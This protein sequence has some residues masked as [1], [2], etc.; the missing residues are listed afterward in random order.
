MEQAL[1]NN[2]TNNKKHPVRRWVF[3]SLAVI[4]NAFII[5]QAS[6]PGEA[7]AL[8]SNFFYNIIRNI[9]NGINGNIAKTIPVDNVLLSYNDSYKY[10]SIEGY[11]NNE[12]PIGVSKSLTASVLP[13]N[14][15]DKMVSFTISD[16][17]KASITSSG[18]NVYVTGLS[19][20]LVTITATSK[21]DINK[22]QT[23]TFNIVEPRVPTSFDYS[24]S[25]LDIY[26]GGQDYLPLVVPNKECYDLTKLTITSLDDSVVSYDDGLLVTHNIG[27]TSI[28]VSNGSVNKSLTVN[29]ID[30]TGATYPI[31]G[32]TVN[33]FD[34]IYVNESKPLSISFIDG[35]FPSETGMIWTSSNPTLASVDSNGVVTAHNKLTSGE[36]IVTITATSK[37]DPTQSVSHNISIINSPVKEFDLVVPVYGTHINDS[38]IDIE[39]TDTYKLFIFFAGYTTDHR[40][41]VTSS[42][43]SVATAELGDGELYITCLKEGQTRISVNN[44][45]YPDVSHYLDV[46]VVPKGAINNGNSNIIKTIIRKSIGHFLLFFM[47]GLFTLLCLNDFLGENKRRWI[48][49]VITL[50]IGLIVAFMSELIQYFCPTRSGQLSDVLIDLGGFVLAVLLLFIIWYSKYKKANKKQPIDN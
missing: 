7:S 45:L 25:T 31:S 23:Y 27:N 28:N 32:W 15:T 37:M 18:N 8:F 43:P 14:A 40:V 44:V 20:G 16:N 33:G 50:S 35:N 24:I 2:V 11:S 34:N 12:I 21:S 9:A 10:S 42:D 3:L 41:N 6:L 29:V 47:S 19:G 5:V 17:S 1:N 13:D 46:T 38:K 4:I 30:P 39:K 22:N 48:K 49:Y 26:N 36:D